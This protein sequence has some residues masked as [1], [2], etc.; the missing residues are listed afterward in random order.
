MLVK[1][2]KAG[3]MAYATRKRYIDISGFSPYKE[4]ENKSVRLGNGANTSV[5]TQIYDLDEPRQITYVTIEDT[6]WFVTDYVYLNGK[7]VQFNLQRDVVG[8]FGL[9]NA[10]GRIERGYTDGILKYRKELSLNEVL[11]KRVPLKSSSDTYGNLTVNT[12]DGEMWGILYFT[13]DGT[14]KNVSVNIPAFAPSYEIGNPPQ[15][16][17]YYNNGDINQNMY[18]EFDML[19]TTK[20]GSR[21]VRVYY[22]AE[23]EPELWV[24]SRIKWGLSSTAEKAP[25]LKVNVDK[26]DPNGVALD[27]TLVLIKQYLDQNN[28]ENGY[29]FP[30]SDGIFGLDT[31][32]A[33]SDGKIYKEGTDYYQ[34][35]KSDVLISHSG[36]VDF[37]LFVSGLNTYLKSQTSNQTTCT[38]SIAGY[39]KGSSTI[40]VPAVKYTREKLP[41]SETGKIEISMTQQ[42]VDEPYCILVFPLY[43]VDLTIKTAEGTS[44]TYPVSKAE[45]FNIF[46]EVI[47]SLSG[48]KAILVDAQIYPYCPF[49]D[50]VQTTLVSNES[51][52]TYPFMSVLS[53]SFETDVA[54]QPRPYMD[55]KKEYITRNY[56][57]VSP[58]QSSKFTFSIYDYVR[59]FVPDTAEVDKNAVSVNIKIKTAL[60][61]FSIISSAVI[62]RVNSLKG[63]NYDSNLEGSQ[64][65]SG[66]FECSLASDAF[67]TYK[68]QNSNYQQLFDI[69]RNELRKNQEVERVNEA[70]QYVMNIATGTAFGAITG[71]QIGDLGVA[72]LAGSKG[73]GAAVG[74]GVSAAAIATT[75]GIQIA[76]NNELREYEREIQQQR[77]DLTIGTIKNLPNSVNRISSFNEI[78]MKDFYYVLETYECTSDEMQVVENFIQ[79]YGYGIGVFDF[80]ENYKK[81]GWFL[82][83][84]VTKSELPIT[85]HQAFKNDIE[86]GVYIYEQK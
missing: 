51:K 9:E 67:E 78:I 43:S 73:I 20:S 2:Y 69:D 33:N 70:M 68:R 81:D 80:L 41:A 76:K 79:N 10:Y 23:Y 60:K 31:A 49:I 38:S 30:S 54:V 6:R 42:L 62:T 39:K 57:I 18:V 85:L 45:A 3:Q 66:G 16:N 47:R 59:D 22:N 64:S 13:K 14:D 17:K 1:Y 83:A 65:A 21:A 5:K 24:G 27:N 15:I 40:S 46:N 35:S 11:V 74:A 4:E 28:P 32:P 37:D 8:E 19:L 84:L 48:E 55:V 29:S 44:V 7:Q 53:T 25:F 63:L 56:S 12:H 71:A 61:P 34:Y 72:N 36:T 58:D 77:F 50:K 86:G 82:K 52:K 26:T 75:G